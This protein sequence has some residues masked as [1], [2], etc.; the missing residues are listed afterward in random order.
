MKFDSFMANDTLTHAMCRTALC[1]Y[2]IS[3]L[4]NHESNRPYFASKRH[5]CVVDISGTVKNL[6][7]NDVKCDDQQCVDKKTL[8]KY[9]APNNT[10]TI[11]PPNL[12]Q[13]V[14]KQQQIQQKNADQNASY[15]SLKP[16]SLHQ[17]NDHSINSVENV[18]SHNAISNISPPNNDHIHVNQVEHHANHTNLPQSFLS[19]RTDKIVSTPRPTCSTNSTHCPHSVDPHPCLVPQPPSLVI[20]YHMMIALPV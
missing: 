2:C 1:E 16:V 9:P 11:S 18:C 6:V 17:N 13:F 15:S 5:Y 20:T 10:T 8:A 3:K 7:P 19:P 4:I 14:N 12:N